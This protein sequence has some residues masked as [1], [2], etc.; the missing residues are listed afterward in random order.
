MMS[1]TSLL[2][3]LLLY[4]LTA[5][6]QTG[7]LKGKVGD[8]Q[9]SSPIQYVNVNLPNGRNSFTNDLGLFYIANI[10][11]G[12]Y[13]L[14]VSHIGYKTEIIPIEIKKNVITEVTVGLKKS[15]LNLSEIKVGGKKAPSLNT[16]AGV[17][18]KLRPV[19][20][21]QDML[22]I[23][24][25]IFIAQHAGGG[26]AEQIF[27]RGYDLDHGTDINI[28]VDGMP[29]NMVSHAHG[30]GYSDLHFLI[31]ETVD[32]INFGYGPYSAQHG[33]MA[34]AG[35]VSFQTKDFVEEN[36]VRLEGGRFNTK[37]ASGI[38]KLVNKE[39]ENIRQ[40]LYLASEYFFSD[41]Y[42]QSPQDFHR[43][44]AMAKYTSLYGDHAQL[45]FIAT[46]FGSRWNASGQVP[47]RAV[48]AG[49]IDRFGSLDNSEGG[50]THRSNFSAIFKKQWNSGWK[51]SDQLF[52]AK[53]DFNLYSNFTFYLKDSINGDEINQKEKRSIYGYKGSLSKN[54]NK[55]NAC[56]EIGYGLRYD[57]IRDIELAH[58]VQRTYLNSFQ[59]G[60]IKEVNAYLYAQQN[61]NWNKWHLTAGLRLDHLHFSYLDKLN[62]RKRATQSASTINPKL[63][64][65]YSINNNVRCFASIGSGFHS[66]DARIALD[67]EANKLLPKVYGID[68]GV[69]LKP[70]K[71]ILLKTTLWKLYS[72]EEFV[73]VGDEGIIEPAGRSMRTGIDISVRYQI[74]KCLFVD[75][76]ANFAQP[77]AIDAPKGE[78]AIP[79]APRFS[80]IGGITVKNGSGLS[81]AIRYRYLQNR[82][83]NETGSVIAKGYFITDL[84][85][86]YQIKKVEFF[87]SIENLFNAEWREAQFDTES[88][89]LNEAAPVTEI[90]YTQ[91]APL[92]FK[93]GLRLIF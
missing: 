73:Y 92:F 78:D 34:T 58:T 72:E 70:T 69:I 55:K 68:A 21:S 5:Y 52:F 53:Y 48:Q 36:S 37:R 71:D 51:S 38:I 8:L 88:R 62:E 56:T 74:A 4:K 11:P 27:L 1:K 12:N 22:R 81:A 50:N 65:D 46:T 6:S 54:W 57:N 24:P 83:A 2:T 90:H 59:K 39:K 64:V 91:G 66:N 9:T 86:D 17:D 82:P 3:I 43:A 85:T 76:D 32:K 16:I 77:K 67:E 42:F 20:S 45:S 79:L 49:I 84:V 40:Q 63:N 80:S 35:Y 29:V 75:F 18:I 15:E 10:H 33:D 26:K 41:G 31:P 7:S 44:N 23:V 89:L 61:I 93:G 30:Q 14:V 60:N 28:S 87:V 47:D 19:N 25:G 13:E